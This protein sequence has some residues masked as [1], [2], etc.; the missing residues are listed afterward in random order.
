VQDRS[1][2]AKCEKLR[3]EMKQTKGG[4]KTAESHHEYY[5]WMIDEERKNEYATWMTSLRMPGNSR[6]SDHAPH[7]HRTAARQRP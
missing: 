4:L 5:P 3:D 7:E 1:A 2:D 6:M